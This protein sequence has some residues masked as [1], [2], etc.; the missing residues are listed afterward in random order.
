MKFGWNFTSETLDVVGN[1]LSE[2]RSDLREL[3][4]I[5]DVFFHYYHNMKLELMCFVQW[6]HLRAFPTL[7]HFISKIFFDNYKWKKCGNIGNL[8]TKSK[9]LIFYKMLMSYGLLSLIMGFNAFFK[10]SAFRGLCY[11]MICL[12]CLPFNTD[13]ICGVTDMHNW[14]ACKLGSIFKLMAVFVD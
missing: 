8:H 13:K 12:I 6:L 14:T 4:G 1:D 10:L 2:A 9:F 7:I 3:V 5:T 11:C